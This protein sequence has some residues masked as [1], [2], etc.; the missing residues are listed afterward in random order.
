MM[1]ADP[2]QIVAGITSPKECEREAE[3]ARQRSADRGWGV[4]AACVERGEFPEGNFTNLALFTE[5]AWH[6]DF[7]R[8]PEGPTMA[9]HVI[10]LRGGNPDAD[11]EML[12]SRDARLSRLGATD[13]HGQLVIFRATVEDIAAGGVVRLT[14]TS[15]VSGKRNGVGPIPPEWTARPKRSWCGEEDHRRSVTVSRRGMQDFW[16]NTGR[17][18]R[19]K[20]KEGVALP[21]PDQDYVFLARVESVHELENDDENNP[22][23]VI[24]LTILSYYAPAAM[25]LY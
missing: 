14:E 10:A 20:L 23:T 11:M 13:Q 19:G 15:S 2:R 24:E 3:V 18:L 7:L 25:S 21:G 1:A 6:S 22:S 5:E 16:C 17:L 9:A 4:L 8:R 12:A